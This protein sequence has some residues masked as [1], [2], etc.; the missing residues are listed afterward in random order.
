MILI[1]LL[2]ALLALAFLLAKVSVSYADPF[3]LI[4][5]RMTIAGLLLLGYHYITASTQRFSPPAW[6]SLCKVAFFHIYLAFIPEFWALQ[7]LPSIKVNLLYS[8]TPFATALLSYFIVNESLSRRQLFGMIVAFLSLIPVLMA[9]TN[10]TFS[11]YSL[12]S[13]S[14]PEL[15]LMCSIISAAYA[16][17]IIKKLMHQGYTL[18]MINGYAMFIAGIWSFI[19]W[20][21]CVYFEFSA[22][23][24]IFDMQ[25]F[26]LSVAGLIM[27]SNVIVYNLYGWLVYHYS[28]TLISLAGF[29]CPIFGAAYGYVLL[30]EALTWHYAVA[31]VGI[32]TGLYIFHSKQYPIMKEIT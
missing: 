14:V 28:I 19:T 2:Y 22:T 3:F 6:R 26:L 11:W 17:F 18:S 25:P 4:G 30:N 23:S 32:A 16:W 24:P 1:I 12:F 9:Q 15:V 20:L 27:L 21:I 10:E 5:F 31:T 29:L 7:F 8:V 13:F